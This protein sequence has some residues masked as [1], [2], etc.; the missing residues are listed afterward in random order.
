MISRFIYQD[1]PKLTFVV[2]INTPVY[3]KAIFF[4]RVITKWTLFCVSGYHKTCRFVWSIKVS[5]S[6][7]SFCQSRFHKMYF[8]FVY[9]T[10]TKRAFVL[11]IKVSQ[12]LFSFCL[13]RYHKTYVHILLLKS[14]SMYINKVYILF[15]CWSI[16]KCAFVLNIL[17]YNKTQVLVVKV[18]QSIY[19]VSK[20]CTIGTNK[21]MIIVFILILYV[22]LIPLF[23]IS[24]K[25]QWKIHV[26]Y[27]L[28]ISGIFGFRQTIRQRKYDSVE[29][30]E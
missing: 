30:T 6:V 8:R 10:I 23:I 12:N 18:P 5:E 29:F 26:S 1:I 19:L 11:S 20:T 21:Q 3:H 13:S 14:L 17:R 4:Y 22:C 24:T 7:L 15:V 9:Q 16:I 25:W 28:I 27:I 2:S